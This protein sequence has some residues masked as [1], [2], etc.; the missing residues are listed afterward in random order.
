MNQNKILHN[1]MPIEINER[2][3]LDK[4]LFL[5]NMSDIELYNFCKTDKDPKYYTST[6]N[7]LAEYIINGSNT[8]KKIYKKNNCNRY[9]CN[10]SLQQLQTDI[11]N[12]IYPDNTYDYD[13]KNCSASIMLYLCKL[14]NLNYTHIENYVKNRDKIIS[15]YNFTKEELKAIVNK[16]SNIDNPYLTNK[17]ELDDFISQFT[18]NKKKLVEIY[19]LLL[20]NKQYDDKKHPIS[21]RYCEI[22]YYFESQ[23]VQKVMNEYKD[24]VIC[25]MFDGFNIT[26]QLD[27]DD[28][29]KI[30]NEYGVEWIMKP[31]VSRF[32]FNKIIT[33][34]N[35]KHKLEKYIYKDFILYDILDTYYICEQ[36]NTYISKSIKYCNDLWF[37]LDRNTNLWKN[38]KEVQPYFLKILRI[39]LSNGK[40]I[41]DK[42]FQ[43]ALDAD[44]NENI[45][46]I[47]EKVE[48]QIKNYTLIDKNSFCGQFKKNITEFITDNEFDNKLDCNMYYFAFKNG[49][50]NMKNKTFRDGIYPTDYLTKTLDFDYSSE[51]NTDDMEW[52]KM[53]LTKIMN[54]NTTHLEFLL[55]ILGQA[56]TGDSEKYKY[57]YF[58]IG[59]LAGNGKSTIFST[60]ENIFSC[61]VKCVESNILETDYS[62]KHKIMPSFK[63]NRIVYLDEMKKG[64]KI[65]S[66]YVK[67]IADGKLYENEI[68]F[69]T[70]NTFKIQAKAFLLLNHMTDF[71]AMDLGVYRRYTHL[72]FDSEFD[73]LNKYKL[74]KDNYEKLKFIPDLKFTDKMIEKKLALTHILLDYAYETYINGIPPMPIEFEEQKELMND[75]NAEINEWLE[76]IIYNDSNEKTSKQEIIDRYK[77][78]FNKSIQTKEVIDIMKQ[79]GYA[80][81]YN[82]NTAKNINGVRYRGVYIGLGLEVK[83][84]DDDPLY[85]KSDDD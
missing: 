1:N 52:Y 63:T 82:K 37:V 50:Y 28:L 14:N 27:L 64:K 49:I 42:K 45:K 12:F 77:S 18:T 76:S 54:N 51:R 15:K 62:K 58:C 20:P 24:D 38:V 65:D 56:L 21:S 84:S 80:K 13:I 10:N 75:C 32:E 61:Y 69:G 48:K 9:Y 4:V 33:Y 30:T 60:L 67:L 74:K 22:F 2:I 59:Q 31:I 23:I 36:Y 57:F 19:K 47:Q 83:L 7:T 3:N 25:Y 46:S 34:D 17:V 79:L 81:Y 72:Q 78:D 66:K 35:I 16:L 5:Y 8:N 26:K 68:L 39:G 6:R 43:E 73:V 11:R 53:E 85:I 29:N 44:D 71:D 40:A 70:T 41:L 55:S